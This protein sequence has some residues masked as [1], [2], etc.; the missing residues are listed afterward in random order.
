MSS[1]SNKTTAFLAVT[2]LTSV[3]LVALIAQ[4]NHTA[5]PGKIRQPSA[6][7]Q[8]DQTQ[9][10]KQVEQL[11]RYETP[12]VEPN[13]PT[14]DWRHTTPLSFDEVK[15]ARLPHAPRRRD[16]AA[17]GVN[18]WVGNL[19]CTPVSAMA[20]EGFEGAGGVGCIKVA[21]NGKLIRLGTW[22]ERRENGDMDAGEF[23][24]GKRTGVWE[25][26][27]KTGV[28]RERG[29]YVDDRRQGRWDE[30]GPEGEHLA[31]RNYHGGAFH[32]VAMLYHRDEP[33]I[34]VWNEGE[35]ISS[36]SGFE[37]EPRVALRGEEAE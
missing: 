28:L 27:S 7:A 22:V 15:A 6:S 23:E 30:F 17:R 18:T 37:V 5:G 20:R 25:R 34:E 35:L 11:Q 4:T 36:K 33:T 16:I 19:R 1:L 29:E 8:Q 9:Q 24:N 2:V 13:K 21:K 14:T 32:G 26:Y 10:A 3:G 12:T 31:Q